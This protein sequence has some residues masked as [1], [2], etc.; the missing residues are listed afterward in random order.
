MVLVVVL[1]FMV[2]ILAWADSI[3]Q[4]RGTHTVYLRESI[5]L[6]LKRGVTYNVMTLQVSSVVFVANSPNIVAVQITHL[7]YKGSVVYIPFT[8]IRV[9]IANK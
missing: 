3:D 2:P 6:E 4:P 7:E 1:S 8:N 5:P 9:I